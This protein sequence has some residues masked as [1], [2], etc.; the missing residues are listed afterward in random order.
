MLILPGIGPGTST[1]GQ[2]C[3]SFN[4]I[5][6]MADRDCY[7]DASYSGPSN[8]SLFLSLPTEL[9]D[10]ILVFLGPLELAL[11][12]STCRLLSRHS[13]SDLCWQQ[14]VQENVP[15]LELNS[16]AP[17][18]TYRELY[19]AHDPHWFLSKY[20]IWFCDYFLTGK[21]I[22]ARYDPRRGCI[23]G[24]HLVSERL[25][26]TYEPWEADD[27]VIVHS[28]TP[29]CKLHMAQPVLHLDALPTE[30]LMASVGSSGPT[31]RLSAETSMRINDRN[32]HGVFSNFLLARPVEERPG[33][34]L[35]PPEII[36]AR[37]RVRNASQEAFVGRGH[38][39][40]KRS[41]ICEQAFRIR[42]WIEMAPG[43]N[44]PGV[45]LGEEVSTYATLDPEVYTPTEDKPW[46]GIWVG[47]YSG[48][49]CE[50]LLMNQPDDEEPFDE[51]LVVRKEDETI[52]EWQIRKKEERIYRGK[53]EGIKLTGD[54][55]VPRGEY[56]FVADDISNEGF[57]RIATEKKFEGARG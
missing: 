20:K 36:P 7:S 37:S 57:I 18:K 56:T 23:E 53:I 15:G 29:N 42:R 5:K 52:E 47:D 40:S 48:H 16:P 50:F 41:E 51:A 45:H 17:C 11:I 14:H 54:P 46:R 12:S 2:I 24:Y 49:G 19:I 32:H 10:H 33:M 39:P 35:W 55:N 43:P 26:P 3:K 13:K 38:K 21:M 22:L 44:V 9:I 28:F 27:E 6:I 8:K 4:Y 30:S 1:W 31:Q 25:N 34:A